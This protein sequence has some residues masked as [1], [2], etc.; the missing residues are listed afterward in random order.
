VPELLATPTPAP[1]LGAADL[2]PEVA[3]LE[4]SGV[5][6][7]VVVGRPSGR[8]QPTG[9]RRRARLHLVAEGGTPPRCGELED[10][11]RLPVDRAELLARAD[12]LLARLAPA[13]VPRPEV[14]A[15]GV[16]RC[17]GAIA[18]VG[19]QEAELLRL[20]LAAR[21]GLAVRADL[22]AALWGA[23]VPS[24]PRALDNRIKALRHHLRTLPLRI[25]TVRGR[26]FLLEV[27]SVG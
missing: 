15:D 26:G 19:P 12:R 20:L 25:S 5:E 3:W 11:V 24:D 10:W 7:V 17:G 18:I 6:V 9:S 2:G 13:E 27:V 8:P 1:R 22:I 14:D 4:A 21:G 23:D 16:V